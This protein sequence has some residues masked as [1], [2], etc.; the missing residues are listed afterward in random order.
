MPDPPLYGTEH[1]RDVVAKL[2]ADRL[3]RVGP[4]LRMIEGGG[5]PAAM[6]EPP[7][8]KTRGDL[9]AF[10]RWLEDAL[11]VVPPEDVA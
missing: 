11:A 3:A 6:P 1:L 10:V 2:K 4:Q 5:D 8:M 9:P 7:Q